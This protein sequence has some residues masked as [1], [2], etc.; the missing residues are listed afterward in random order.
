MFVYYNFLSTLA[1]FV[2]DFP[3]SHYVETTPVVPRHKYPKWNVLNQF[4]GMVIFVKTD[5]FDAFLTKILPTITK[6]FV[7]LT[8]SSDCAISSGYRHVAEN[9]QLIKW[10]G[11]NICFDHIKLTKVV[12][13]VQ[14]QEYPGGKQE[15]LKILQRG[16][17]DFDSRSSEI[18]CPSFSVTHQSRKHLL[19]RLSNV[20]VDKVR[21]EFIEYM[22]E[23]SKYK[24]VLCMR[25]NGIDTHRVTESLIMGCVPIV[26]HTELDE[27]YNALGCYVTDF[28]NMTLKPLVQASHDQVKRITCEWV[29]D[30]V[31][32]YRGRWD[33]PDR[34]SFFNAL[35][36][37]V[38]QIQ[39]D[40]S[41]GRWIRVLSTDSRNRAFLE[42]GTWNGLGSTAVFIDSLK[43]RKKNDYVFWSLECN[44]EKWKEASNQYKKDNNIHLL[45]EV[46]WKDLPDDFFEVFPQL[47]N[48]PSAWF[49][50]DMRGMQSC[51]LFLDR[52]DLPDIFDVVLLDGGEYSTF[53]EF[54]MLKHRTRTF[55]LGGTQTEKCCKILEIMRKSPDKWKIEFETTRERNGVAV[56]RNKEMM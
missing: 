28:Q 41:L 1:D 17:P 22:A 51:K 13:G 42:S 37:G 31:E 34:V 48:E 15:I 9:N 12:V 29:S 27:M 26:E 7:L 55:I 33:A 14:E 39:K 21:R 36:N 47:Q 3:L 20:R 30:Q 18:Y 52:V 8:G 44:Q 10:F 16:S 43:T 6:R 50:T 24:Y 45:N 32:K 40:D 53:H 23:I 11:T 4:D 2:F 46:L 38:G 25:G 56:V 19:Q 5:M 49:K 54:Q 35:H